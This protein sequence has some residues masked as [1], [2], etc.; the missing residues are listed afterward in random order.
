MS[1][2]VAADESLAHALQVHP[3]QLTVHK[4]G[5]SN[6][7]CT[8]KGPAAAAAVAVQIGSADMDLSPLLIPRYC[9]CSPKF[10]HAHQNFYYMLCD[11]DDASS[12]ALQNEKGGIEGGRELD[13]CHYFDRVYVPGPQ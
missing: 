8:A 7:G 1:V 5:S 13:E 11:D 3:L 12:F 2:Q 9:S 6:T 10:P 4:Q